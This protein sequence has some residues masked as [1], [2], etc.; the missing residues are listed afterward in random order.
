ML[1]NSISQRIMV[2]EYFTS[3]SCNRWFLIM[4]IPQSLQVCL[5]L[6]KH[7]LNQKYCWENTWG[8]LKDIIWVKELDSL[9]RKEYNKM[10]LKK[11]SSNSQL[12]IRREKLNV[13]LL[14]LTRVALLIRGGWY[15]CASFILPCSHWRCLGITP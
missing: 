5:Y 13:S 10:D 14:L 6:A 3:G 9:T 12:P 4:P 8:Q 2:V 7:S 15:T 1:N 11:D